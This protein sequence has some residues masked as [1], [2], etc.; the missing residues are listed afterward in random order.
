MKF[1]A[2]LL[3]LVVFASG[4]EAPPAV[5]D[6]QPLVANPTRD[7]FDFATLIY[8]TAADEKDPVKKKEGFLQA[9]RKFDAFLRAY[10]KD[11]KALDSSWGFATDKS[12][13]RKPVD[14]A[15][16]PSPPAGLKGNLWKHPRSISPR[17]T[18]M[19]RN[20]AVLQNGLQLPQRS[21]RTKRSAKSLS[22][23]ASFATAN[24]KTTPA[25]FWH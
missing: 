11:E 5:G 23:V 16:K 14:S 7:V 24:S 9:A 10:P 19:P 3:C 6:K 12:A 22:I 4:Q 20:G 18:M 25:P 13:R 17:T 21:P 2:L 15:S 1:F 8:N